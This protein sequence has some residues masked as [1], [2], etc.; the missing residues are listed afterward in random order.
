VVHQYQILGD[1]N[2]FLGLIIPGGWEE[3]FRSIGDPYD[4]PMW[5][6]EDA[7]GIEVLLSRLKDAVDKHDYVPMPDLPHF[8]PQPWDDDTNCSLP[9]TLTPYFLRAGRGPRYRVGGLITTPLITTAESNHAF[10]VGSVEGSSS[11]DH[12]PVSKGVTFARSHHCFYVVDGFLEL[13]VDG[14]TIQ[15]G[16]TETLYI[17]RGTTFALR[18]NSRYVKTYIF[19]NGGGLLEALC[20]VGTPYRGPMIPEKDE[21]V[22]LEHF[23]KLGLGQYDLKI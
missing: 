9:G 21:L 3:F 23:Q 7:R 20:K 2:E 15:L 4:G 18:F 22:D 11:H 14:S 8:G 6:L 16:P 19:A 12:N 17:P 5:P 10:S 13:V 1:H